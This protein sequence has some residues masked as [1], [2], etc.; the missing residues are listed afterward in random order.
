ME[1]PAKPRSAALFFVL[2]LSLK[3]QS[4]TRISDNAPDFFPFIVYHNVQLKL[5]NAAG[6]YGE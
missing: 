6:V 5:S 3:R 2:P 4:E 1:I